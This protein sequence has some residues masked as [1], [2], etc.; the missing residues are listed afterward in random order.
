MPA[1]T[2]PQTGQSWRVRWSAMKSR[3]STMMA[4][5]STVLEAQPP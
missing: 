4:L 2:A 1:K 3:M 5:K